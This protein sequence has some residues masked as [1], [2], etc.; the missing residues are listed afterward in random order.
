[1]STHRTA[2]VTIAR[3]RHEHLRGQ[4]W[5][6]RRQSR[7]A[8]LHVVV[9]MGDPEVVTVAREVLP[10]VHTSFMDAIGADLPL[11][12]A[13]NVGAAVALE[14]G[15]DRL[16][17]LDVDCI[18]AEGTVARYDEVLQ[19]V[20]ARPF[21]VVVCGEVAY[22]P[23][24]DHPADY[25]RPGLCDLADPHP[26]R[27]RLAP[28]E[29]AEDGDVRLFWSLSFGVTADHWR[30]LGGFSEDYTGY[31]AEDT[32]FGQR[33][34]AAGGSLVWTGGAAAYH[35]HHPTSSPPTQHLHSIVNNANVF[36]DIWGWFPMQGWLDGFAEL[37]LARM[38]PSSGRWVV[39]H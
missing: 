10:G 3:G 6:L 11:A 21:P 18:P 26:A 7:P 20:S 30:R 19:G 37:G 14:A 12:S 4:A 2:V 28:R 35:Q 25:R 38:D 34:A 22:L 23:P 15:A 29:V 27:P 17:F 16:V 24:A 5:G 32:D 33:L 36:R 9:S 8:D 13:R 39:S 1:M 31:G